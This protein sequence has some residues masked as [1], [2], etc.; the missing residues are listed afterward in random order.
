M[1]DC[2]HHWLI[3]PAA[4]PTSEGCCRFCG[5][6]RT[7]RNSSEFTP[8]DRHH[9]TLKAKDILGPRL[10]EAGYKE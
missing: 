2:R 1:D 7:F 10:I 4:G 5:A 9:Q 8:A 3:E 6:V